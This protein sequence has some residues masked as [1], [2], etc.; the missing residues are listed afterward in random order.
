MSLDRTQRVIVS[1]G[2]EILNSRKAGGGR[3]G[4]GG[5]GGGQNRRRRKEAFAPSS[6][7]AEAATGFNIILSSTTAYH[8]HR[9]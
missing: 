1:T 2:T 6:P 7:N 8:R 9:N 4:G 3:E 5:G